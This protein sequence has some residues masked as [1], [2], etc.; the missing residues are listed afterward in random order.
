MGSSF[1]R[2]ALLSVET[3]EPLVIRDK[4]CKGA[5]YFSPLYLPSS[6][7]S[8]AILS[9]LIRRGK[10]SK[11][12]GIWMSHAFPGP[13]DGKV[14]PFRLGEPP[15]LPLATISRSE[16]GEYVSV[17]LIFAKAM[18]DGPSILKEVK[19]LSRKVEPLFFKGTK[20]AFR[21]PEK[22]V[23]THVALNYEGRTYAYEKVGEEK[24]GLLFTEEIIRPGSRFFAIAF[25]NE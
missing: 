23:Y 4:Y 22:E 8:G 12:E 16:S 17:A 21:P 19:A 18:R 10:L 6:T 7:L 1:D 3:L 9:H 13:R 5:H 15:P 2:V 25:L 14:P 24:Y 11:P 20:D